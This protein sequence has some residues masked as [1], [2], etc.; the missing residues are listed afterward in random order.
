MDSKKSAGPDSLD[1][2]FLKLAADLIAKPLTCLFNLSLNTNKLPKVWKSAF[3]LPLLK[4]GDPSSVN[5]Y[6]PISK[7]C[8]LA[9]VFEKLV[10]DQLK[11]FLQEKNI[12]NPLQS[13]FRRQHSTT[14]AALK[15]FNDVFE[16][17][18]SKMFCAA[19]FIDLAKAS[20]M[21]DHSLLVEILFK[22]GISKLAA[23]WFADYLANRTQCVQ[24][25]GVSSTFLEVTKGVRQGS[26]LGPVLF[27]IYI[28]DLCTNLSNASYHLYADDS[29]IYC[30]SSLIGQA[31]KLLQATF[32]T[33]QSRLVN[34]KLVLND[35]K[36]KVML[37]SNSSV[38]SETIPSI[39]TAGGTVLE[40]VTKYKYLGLTVDREL[41]FKIHVRNLISKS[42]N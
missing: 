19:P 32:D 13:G 23:S 9:K 22:N 11:D 1:P 16:A 33:V 31:F 28:N 34:L 4:G 12:L 2:F 10:C 27:T 8:I 5:N 39:K 36:S 25:A 24:L 42:R 41:T 29:V 21:V 15:V 40:L 37:F 38:P 30:C 17:L 14:A 6:R 20:D 18:D 3:V 35:E 7:L 26:V